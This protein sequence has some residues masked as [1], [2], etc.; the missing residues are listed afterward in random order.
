MSFVVLARGM[1]DIEEVN[2]MEREMLERVG[3]RVHVGVEEL[4]DFEGLLRR[5]SARARLELV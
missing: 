3:W 5:E 2:A 4:R 1:F